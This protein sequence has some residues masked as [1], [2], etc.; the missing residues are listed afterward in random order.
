MRM[1]VDMKTNKMNLHVLRHGR[2]FLP[3]SALVLAVCTPATLVAG[4]VQQ[5]AQVGFRTA[6][7]V[8]AVSSN[9]RVLIP[10]IA[11]SRRPR[12]LRM[13]AEDPAKKDMVPI[14]KGDPDIL[15][16][17]AKDEAEAGNATGAER[18]NTI[19][20]RM[21]TI[22]DRSAAKMSSKL[23]VDDSADAG[24]GARWPYFNDRLIARGRDVWVSSTEQ[25]PKSARGASAFGAGSFV[26]W[27]FR[28][29]QLSGPL[30]IGL[31]SLAVD[32]D[33]EWT[34]DEYFN[35]ALYITQ[36]CN[37][38]NGGQLI[39]TALKPLKA[40]DIVD[41][42]LDGDMIYVSVN[43]VQLP[44]TLGPISNS[45]RPSVQLHAMDDGISLLEQNA[46]KEEGSGTLTIER[47]KR[48]ELATIDDDTSIISSLFSDPS[49]SPS[50]SVSELSADEPLDIFALNSAAA[51]AQG[52]GLK[53]K[54]E[55][56]VSDTG[57]VYY[58]NKAT[59]ATSW[60]R[61]DD[62]LAT[63]AELFLKEQSEMEA[64]RLLEKTVEDTT[65]LFFN[66]AD[67]MLDSY[68][69]V[70]IDEDGYPMLDRFVYVDEE[71]CIGCT[72]C[73]TVARSTFMMTDE[74][75]RARVFRQGGDS[76]DLVQE[77]VSTCPVDCI[78]YV[79]WDDLVILEGERKGK[80]INNQ[81]RLVGGSN[82]EATGYYG[83]GG[84]GVYAN[85]GRPSSQSKAS[86][87]KG[88]TR[89]NNCPGRGCRTCPLY[90][91]GQNPEYAR[92]KAA[93]KTKRQSNAATMIDSLGPGN[94]L[95]DDIDLT[96]IFSGDSYTNTDDT[97][98]TETSRYGKTD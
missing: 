79:S 89:C 34:L 46:R 92:K 65:D 45:L 83:S 27:K 86:I 56:L 8:K 6:R 13:S 81:A 54:W 14:R 66:N 39:W 38:Y 58:W 44:A 69:T 60:Q 5:P 12:T 73:A 87:M 91:V 20:D 64:G 97:T 74:L 48:K 98:P 4:F 37:M 88:G 42:T 17:M 55:M 49:D 61:P 43:D 75:G 21:Q 96:S 62:Y 16:A 78:W 77:A 70:R 19:A 76:D 36:N 3:L 93:R 23:D 28:V 82:I 29:N 1:T 47:N 40:G 80:V 90:G 11:A 18:L 52:K 53:N 22:M 67:G 59:N 32:L 7:T 35:E 63:D 51:P 85:Q 2:Y 57:R 71:T 25:G 26:T 50:P 41:F 84:W 72:N 30:C 15:K 68:K 9:I 10:A 33:R 95:S 94:S 31:T 24:E